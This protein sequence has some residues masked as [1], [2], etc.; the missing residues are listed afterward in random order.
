[1]ARALTRET[2]EFAYRSELDLGA[3][4]RVLDPACGSGIFLKEALRELAR[5]DSNAHAVI[6]GLDISDLSVVMSRF[7]VGRAASDAPFE[8]TVD[9][10]VDDALEAEWRMPHIV[11]MNPPFVQ[12]E[13]LDE[14]QRASAS[15]VLGAAAAGRFDL[16]MAFIAKAS[17]EIAD[18]GVLTSL[19]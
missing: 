3:N 13:N 11:L 16:S 14:A 7:V 17:T 1:M 6:R 19:L 2:F 18:A 9:I 12:V 4:V 10:T 15:R 5:R 8:V